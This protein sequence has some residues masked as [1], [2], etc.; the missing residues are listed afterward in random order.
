MPD[1]HNKKYRE[2]FENLNSSIQK[3][4]SIAF[5]N[6]VHMTRQEHLN[7]HEILHIATE[8][9]A[10]YRNNELENA[11]RRLQSINRKRNLNR[12]NEDNKLN[13]RAK[14][15]DDQAKDSKENEEDTTTDHLWQNFHNSLEAVEDAKIKIANHLKEIEDKQAEAE[16]LLDKAAE[17]EIERIGEQALL[18]AEHCH[19]YMQ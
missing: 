10:R 11:L 4:L 1:S 15:E 8:G 18:D 17:L 19:S 2:K 5:S 6:D 14:K 12:D 16:E 3:E 7:L 9:N 13:K